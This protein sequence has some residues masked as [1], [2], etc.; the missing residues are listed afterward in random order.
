M[1]V[2]NLGKELDPELHQSEKTY[3]GTDTP[4]CFLK[5]QA[6]FEGQDF[7]VLSAS[8]AA[9]MLSAE[10]QRAYLANCE[11]K[12]SL[13]QEGE[14]IWGIQRADSTLVLFKLFEE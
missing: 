1:K 12:L 13:T 10:D 2:K 3:E 9:E 14:Q 7:L 5:L 6:P 4:I 8:A 11:V